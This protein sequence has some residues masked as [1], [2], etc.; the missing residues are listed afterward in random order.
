MYNKNTHYF[1]R[2]ETINEFTRYYISFTDGN[3][4]HNETEVSRPVYREFMRFKKIERNLRH[5]DERH[6]EYSELT[7]EAL[8]IRALL[9]SKSLED[10]V[11]DNIRYEHLRHAIQHL[12]DKQRRRFIFHYDFGLTYNQI[13]EK[14][15]CSIM[16]VK[17]SIDRAIKNIRRKIKYF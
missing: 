5:W 4:N 10:V 14:E 2:A 8:H 9:P 12:P 13:A 6:R 3:G 17:R 7:D 11:F 15:G 16:P 1:L